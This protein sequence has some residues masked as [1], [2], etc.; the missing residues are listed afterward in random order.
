MPTQ[1][2]KILNEVMSLIYPRSVFLCLESAER[3]LQQET[4]S[5]APPTPPG[6]LRPQGNIRNAIATYS[7]LCVW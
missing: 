5:L 4:L 7:Q 3:L 6:P 1:E 2:F